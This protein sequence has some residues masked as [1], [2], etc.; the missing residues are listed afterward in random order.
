VI[1]ATDAVGEVAAFGEDDDDSEA[2]FL[3]IRLLKRRTSV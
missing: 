1:A 2:P 3:K